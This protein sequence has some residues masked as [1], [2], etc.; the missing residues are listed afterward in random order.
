MEERILQLAVSELEYDEKISFWEYTIEKRYSW[1]FINEWNKRIWVFVDWAYF[2]NWYWNKSYFESAVM[3]NLFVFVDFISKKVEELHKQN[4]DYYFTVSRLEKEKSELEEK[5]SDKV[6][7][8]TQ[9]NLSD[10]DF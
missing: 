6:V 9:E 1:T 4:S 5:I 10:K 3:N 2:I 7:E 8:E